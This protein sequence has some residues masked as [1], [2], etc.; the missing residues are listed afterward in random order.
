MSTLRRTDEKEQETFY[1]VKGNFLIGFVKMTDAEMQ[2]NLTHSVEDFSHILF[3]Y[4]VKRIP[5]SYDHLAM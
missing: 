1:Y 5:L 4:I 3:V 2:E